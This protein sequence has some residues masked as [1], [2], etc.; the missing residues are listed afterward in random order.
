MP[1]W[2]WGYIPTLEVIVDQILPFGWSQILCTVWIAYQGNCIVFNRLQSECLIFAYIIALWHILFF[3][4]WSWKL[5]HPSWRF[6]FFSPTWFDCHPNA[7][8]VSEPRHSSRSWMNNPTLLRLICEVTLE[9]NLS[10]SLSLSHLAFELWTQF[11]GYSV[12]HSSLFVIVGHCMMGT[13]LNPHCT[14][15]S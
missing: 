1:W 11:F 13:L 9:L 15:R 8:T 10:L 4:T 5:C 2:W 6:F 14:S 12:C 7:G 3:S